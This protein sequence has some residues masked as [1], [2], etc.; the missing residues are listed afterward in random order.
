MKHKN[1][2]TELEIWTHILILKTCKLTDLSVKTTTCNYM[3]LIKIILLYFTGF[4]RL[5]S[6][7]K[8]EILDISGNEFDK[9]ALKS[10]GTIASLKTLVLSNMGLNGSFPLQGMLYAFIISPKLSII[11]F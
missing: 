2:K 5:S 7:K 6:L 8:L 1:H 10:L 4:K 9:S 3:L 11:Y